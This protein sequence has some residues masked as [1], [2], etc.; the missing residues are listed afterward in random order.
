MTLLRY[1]AKEFD[2]KLSYSGHLKTV[3]YYAKSAIK[4]ISY[5]RKVARVS[6]H[7]TSLSRFVQVGVGAGDFV[8]DGA[9]QEV[10]GVPRD[11]A[12]AAAAEEG[13]PQEEED[14]QQAQGDAPDRRVSEQSCKRFCTCS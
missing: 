1:P 12:G 9:V 2:I 10:G 3:T 14:H 7:A 4:C 13:R 5:L 11:R 8:R 6:H